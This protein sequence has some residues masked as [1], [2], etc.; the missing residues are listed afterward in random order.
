MRCDA[1]RCD[2]VRSE[3]KRREE[4]STPNAPSRSPFPLLP[5]DHVVKQAGEDKRDEAARHRADEVDEQSELRDGHRDD[6]AARDERRAEHARAEE[7]GAGGVRDG[8][9]LSSGCCVALRCVVLCCVVLCCVV[10]C[11]VVEG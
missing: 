4:K 8:Q 7:E 2:A 11:C 1:M 9:A 6:A 10:L 5:H 3:E